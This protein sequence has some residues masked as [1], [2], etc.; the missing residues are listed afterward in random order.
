LEL[1]L[2]KVSNE[3]HA[4]APYKV[5]VVDTLDNSCEESLERVKKLTSASDQLHFRN[6]DIRDSQGLAKGTKL[7]SALKVEIFIKKD[8]RKPL[9]FLIELPYSFLFA[10]FH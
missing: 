4:T 7:C 6:V 10:M 2:Q 5:V 3:Q 1:L 9:S 8:G